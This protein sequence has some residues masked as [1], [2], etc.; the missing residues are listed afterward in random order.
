MSVVWL[1]FGPGPW[2][3]GVG[4][5]PPVD[6]RLPASACL[7]WKIIGALGVLLAWALALL[8][9]INAAKVLQGQSFKVVGEL[10]CFDP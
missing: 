10:I 4:C 6:P 1:S 8:Q 9:V 7:T 2:V 3:A 5:S